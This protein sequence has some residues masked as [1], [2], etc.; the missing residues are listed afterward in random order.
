MKAD[1]PLRFIN[2]VINEFQKGK[3]HGDERFII[4]PDLFGITEAFISVEIL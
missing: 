4:P 1:Y 3:N 2:N